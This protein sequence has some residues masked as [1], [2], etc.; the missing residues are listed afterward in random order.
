MLHVYCCCIDSISVMRY[1]IQLQ[2]TPAIEDPYR[3]REEAD[4]KA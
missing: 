2:F 4:F 3:L 1:K